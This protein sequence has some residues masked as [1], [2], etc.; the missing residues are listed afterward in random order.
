MVSFMYVSPP[1]SHVLAAKYWDETSSLKLLFQIC[2]PVAPA[3]PSAHEE[4][5]AP[6]KPLCC[7]DRSRPGHQV[8]LPHH[9]QQ[10]YSV[11]QL[12]CGGHTGEWG[13]VIRTGDILVQPYIQRHHT[14]YPH[15]H[16]LHKSKPQSSVACSP[17]MYGSMSCYLLH[18]ELCNY[19]SYIWGGEVRGNT[20]RGLPYEKNV[21][22]FVWL[23]DVIYWH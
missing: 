1:S 23:S 6:W 9:R 10:P 21:P 15:Q 16:W 14:H 13:A 20:K 11:L 5:S 7:S 8:C 19:T 17:S 3:G 2:S 22:W 18:L 4:V 12:P